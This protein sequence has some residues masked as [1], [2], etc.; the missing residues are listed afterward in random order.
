MKFSQMLKNYAGEY[1]KYLLLNPLVMVGEVAMETTIPLMT[2]KLID[3]VIPACRESG[4]IGQALLYGGL[5]ILMAV[6]S[7]GFGMLGSYFASKGAIGFGRNL[8]QG[9]FE[10]VQRFSF[11]NI[12]HFSTASLV[13][14]LTTDVNQVQGM[15]MMIVRPQGLLPPRPRRYKLPA[16][17]KP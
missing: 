12:D 14:R 15:V 7:M 16:E 11:K 4:S 8:R 5:M 3:D 13:T 6:L 17:A 10:R 1:K 9:M 2:A